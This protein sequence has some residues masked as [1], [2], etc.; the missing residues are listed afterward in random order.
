V[1]QDTPPPLPSIDDAHPERSVPTP[2]QQMANPLK[3]GDLLMELGV[4][5]DAAAK[6]QDHAAAARY[7][8]ALAKAVPDRSYA[9]SKLCDELEAGGNRAEAIDA[10]GTALTRHGATAGDFTR[11]V[12]LLLAKNG[13]LTDAERRQADAAVAALEHEPRAALIATRVRCNIAVHEREVAALELCVNQLQAA[14]PDAAS[15]LGF[16]WA[17]AVE[18]GD[19]RAA[20]TLRQRALAAGLDPA[21]VGTATPIPPGPRA[22]RWARAL[23]WGLE[24]VVL[25]GVAVVG[26]LAVRRLARAGRRGLAF[27]R[28]ES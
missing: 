7:Y 17:L 4:R 16:A 26:A 2:A 8:A 28:G 25:F 10:C 18:H 27:G 5:A 3:F 1:A 23:R 15:T 24:A 21:V 14:E 12:R 11:F 13:P 9:Y 22:R 20:E 6:R 19:R